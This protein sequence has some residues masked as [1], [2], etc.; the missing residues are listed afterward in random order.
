M[1]VVSRLTAVLSA[2]KRACTIVAP[3]LTLPFTELELGSAAAGGISDE[4]SDV[5]GR[6]I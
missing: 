1:S 4:E 5:C 6:G 3:P 2:S